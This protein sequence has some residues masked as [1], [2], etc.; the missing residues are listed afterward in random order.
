[1]LKIKCVRLYPTSPGD[2]DTTFNEKFRAEL[3]ADDCIYGTWK[4]R[5]HKTFVQQFW[6][7]ESS[8]EIE[9]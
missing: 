1:M 5:M 6:I 7:N 2:L 3:Q 4:G 9:N 8:K